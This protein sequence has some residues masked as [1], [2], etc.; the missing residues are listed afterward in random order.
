[1]TWFWSVIVGWVIINVVFVFAALVRSAIRDREE[2]SAAES[3]E[4]Q[5]MPSGSCSIISRR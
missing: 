3:G 4:A 2:T 5:Y 1:M